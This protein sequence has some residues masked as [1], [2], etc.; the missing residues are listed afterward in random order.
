MSS[1]DLTDTSGI[2]QVE[3]KADAF[4][5][6]AIGDLLPDYKELNVQIQN[7]SNK[8]RNKHMEENEDEVSL[9]ILWQ[10]MLRHRSGYSW[11][12]WLDWISDMK[13]R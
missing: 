3:S 2:N 4:P 9:Q 12:H 10:R 6:E 5:L 8:Y 7:H 1:F 11:P 13:L